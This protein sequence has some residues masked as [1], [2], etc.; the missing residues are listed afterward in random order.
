MVQSSDLKRVQISDHK[1]VQTISIPCI[2][3]EVAEED[4]VNEATLVGD[5]QDLL[6]L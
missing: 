3:P 1:R 6:N 5:V 4:G 2:A